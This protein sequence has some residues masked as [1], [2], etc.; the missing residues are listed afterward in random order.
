MAAAVSWVEE[1][2]GPARGEER[3]GLGVRDCLRFIEGWKASG[4]GDGKRKDRSRALTG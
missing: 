4:G 3:K 1:R 2:A